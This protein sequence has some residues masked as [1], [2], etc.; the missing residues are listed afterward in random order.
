MLLNDGILRQIFAS[1]DDRTAEIIRQAGRTARIALLN[2]ADFLIEQPP[3]IISI[4]Y[5]AVLF[6]PWSY[7]RKTHDLSYTIE[8]GLLK[9]SFVN[10]T[11]DVVINHVQ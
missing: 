9:H 10:G 6:L 2:L 4:Y 11:A 5:A 8:S 1:S 7:E 3:I